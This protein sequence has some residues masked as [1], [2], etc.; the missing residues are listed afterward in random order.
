MNGKDLKVYI[1]GFLTSKGFKI[2]LEDKRAIKGIFRGSPDWMID[3]LIQR[4]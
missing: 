3:L 1:L 2:R 4:D